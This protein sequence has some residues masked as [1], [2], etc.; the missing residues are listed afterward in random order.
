MVVVWTIV[1]GHTAATSS[2][3]LAQVIILDE[4]EAKHF[5]CKVCASIRNS[6]TSIKDSV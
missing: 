3:Y 4:Q 2:P 6:L 1:Y 5:Y